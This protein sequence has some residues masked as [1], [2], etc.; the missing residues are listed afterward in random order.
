MFV[1][2]NEKTGIPSNL[3][4][5]L[6]IC[7]EIP[8]HGNGRGMNTVVSGALLIWEYTRQHTSVS[9]WLTNLFHK[10]QRENE[11]YPLE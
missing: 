10:L 3:L 4:P 6:N 9:S 1:V 7:V 8:E 11:V 2:R 5:L